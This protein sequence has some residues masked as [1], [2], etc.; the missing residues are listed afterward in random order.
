ML[1]CHNTGLV[2]IDIQGKLATLMEESEQYIAHCCALIAGAKQLDLP[3]IW[4][5]QNPEK[6][7]S[8]QPDILSLLDGIKPIT[9]FTFDA[10][11]EPSFLA[12]IAKEN[13]PNWLICGIEAHICVY[14]TAASLLQNNYQVHLVNDCIAAR[15]GENKQL[16][17]NKLQHLGARITGL[18]M[19]L[20]ELVKD[21][22][23]ERFKG[24]LNLIK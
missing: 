17:V 10:C 1:N 13:K 21:C 12:A 23:D 3:I 4:L 15:K 11:R 8:T 9:K 7:G 14:Q 20:F 24:I 19:A 18:E 5:E 6:L 16:A 22:R 2:I